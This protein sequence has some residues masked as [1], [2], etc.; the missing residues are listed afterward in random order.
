MKDILFKTHQT[1]IFNRFLKKYLVVILLQVFVHCEIWEYTYARGCSKKESIL[2][3]RLFS[4]PNASD[5]NL[6][7]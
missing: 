4:L 6:A 7:F 2:I 1:V 5:V 3:T